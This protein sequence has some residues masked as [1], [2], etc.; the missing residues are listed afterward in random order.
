MGAEADRRLLGCRIMNP[1]DVTK[2]LA[3][4]HTYVEG[5]RYGNGQDVSHIDL[6]RDHS[7]RVLENT[8]HILAELNGDAAGAPDETASGA[9][10][11]G[12][13][14]LAALFHDIGRF[15]QYLRYKT[16][17][18][19]ES[20]DHGLL[21]AQTL[22]RE[23][24]LG[25]LAEGDRTFVIDAVC[26]HNRITVPDALPEAVRFAVDIIRDADKL[27]ILP[28]IINH[29]RRNEISPSPV[30]FYLKPHPSAYTE[31]VYRD[32]LAGRM[33]RFDQMQWVNDFKLAMCGWV[34]DLNFPVTRRLICE[35]G[36]F[37]A[38]F[39][40]LPNGPEMQ[41]LAD[42]LAATLRR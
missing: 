32:V 7:L 41:K 16:F 4:F 39:D 10:F 29:C 9:S 11:K 13:C 22:E 18:D 40:M 1:T 23:G 37:E 36:H 14:C 31:A 24:F 27:D 19:R 20:E 6:K 2:Y 42:R 12:L 26:F 8:R 34:Y 25:G 35:Q 17:N 5:F 15:P 3:V 28:V 21:G 33:A 30:T 38:L